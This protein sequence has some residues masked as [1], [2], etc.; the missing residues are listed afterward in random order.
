MRSP[1]LGG[2]AAILFFFNWQLAAALIPFA[3]FF[4]YLFVRNAKAVAVATALVVLSARTD[5][6]ALEG[7]PAALAAS[8][9]ACVE[10]AG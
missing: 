1:L 7:C 5:D 8:G 2:G 9:V 6:S 10:A 3:G 4:G